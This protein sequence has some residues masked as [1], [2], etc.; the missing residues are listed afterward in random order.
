MTCWYPRCGEP[1]RVERVCITHF[2]RWVETTYG[3]EAGKAVLAVLTE[4]A[5]TAV[6]ATA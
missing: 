1:V 2:V 4:A 3:S 5:A 6:T